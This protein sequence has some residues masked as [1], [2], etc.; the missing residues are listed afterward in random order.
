[1]SS[2][3]AVAQTVSM[4]QCVETGDSEDVEVE[5]VNWFEDAL[6]GIDMVL[7]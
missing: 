6:I 5:E 3:T 4:R 7:I 1:M 2:E